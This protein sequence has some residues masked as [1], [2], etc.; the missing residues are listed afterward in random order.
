MG[1]HESKYPA[2]DVGVK[3]HAAP[4]DGQVSERT[5]GDGHPR[6]II[7]GHDI[8]HRHT[9]AHQNGIEILEPD[10]GAT[11][12]EVGVGVGDDA[13]DLVIQPTC[14]ESCL[15]DRQELDRG[16]AE[17][18]VAAGLGLPRTVDP[19]LDALHLVALRLDAIAR[20]RL[21]VGI[22]RARRGAAG[23]HGR[24]RRRHRG[25]LRADRGDRRQAG[26]LGRG[27]AG[28]QDHKNSGSEVGETHAF[29]MGAPRGAG[30]QTCQQ[31]FTTR[32]GAMSARMRLKSLIQRD[33]RPPAG[34]AACAAEACIFEMRSPAGTP[35]ETPRGMAVRG[36]D[37]AHRFL[38]LRRG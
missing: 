6:L 34:G 30:N 12:R 14:I 8:R 11:E 22:A 9:S 2:V 29:D 17:V 1:R 38:L 36:H 28:D 27:R 26:I 4:Q 23:R 3:L 16:L 10:L 20:Q 37:F 25:R 7:R 15:E 18:L 24:R 35:D 13:G 33:N 32:G 21:G 5:E 31:T 19:G